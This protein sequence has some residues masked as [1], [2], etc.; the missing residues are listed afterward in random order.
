MQYEDDFR[1]RTFSERAPEIEYQI[2]PYGVYLYS[3]LNRYLSLTRR[4]DQRNVVIS[5]FE[6]LLG[7]KREMDKRK[8][9]GT[10]P[11]RDVSI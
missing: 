5:T 1:I 9:I 2:T 4:R 10:W 6:N 11:S 7:T 8:I 3:R